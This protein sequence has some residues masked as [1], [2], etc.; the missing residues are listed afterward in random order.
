[1]GSLREGL[2]ALARGLA[3]IPI[4]PML[5]SFWIRTALVG[6]DR[7][8][9][10]SC[11]TLSLIPGL[12]G[13]YLR[14]AFLGCV[15]DRCHPSATIEFG[16]LFSKV[17]AQIDENVYI[18]SR[19]HIGLVHLERNVL[20]GPG[21][22]VISGAHTHGTGDLETPIRDQA[23]ETTLVRIGAGSWIGSAAVVMADVGCDTV[24]GAGAVVARPLPDRVIAVGVPA[25][26]IRSRTDPA[27]GTCS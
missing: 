15:L 21:V 3:L 19:C 11:Q 12:T 26:V 6:R 7:A 25:R 10:A 5:L 9:Q 8:F 24:V 23:L 1:M 13:Q 17:A 16:V 18:G 2:K 14:R 4:A 20:L 22:Q 27:K